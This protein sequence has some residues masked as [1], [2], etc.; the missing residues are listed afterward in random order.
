MEQ[1]HIIHRTVDD[2]ENGL[3]SE[4]EFKSSST[5]K[6]ET[7]ESKAVSVNVKELADRWTS[8]A[9]ISSLL[10]GIAASFMSIDLPP[11]AS[12]WLAHSA[13]VSLCV[14]FVSCLIA[15]CLYMF[16]STDLVH[17]MSRYHKVSFDQRSVNGAHFLAA[18]GFLALMCGEFVMSIRDDM[19]A[20]ITCGAICQLV[21]CGIGL[22]TWCRFNGQ[23]ALAG[24]S[25]VEQK[26]GSRMVY[27][28]L[29]D[30]YTHEKSGD[31]FLLDKD[32]FV[33]KFRNEGAMLKKLAEKVFDSWVE[34]R[35]EGMLDADPGF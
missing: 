20:G 11:T 27:A 33:T 35:L 23:M 34:H 9:V 12:P 15:A 21:L 32:E 17:R 16:F 22:W 25:Q 30:Y 8:L 13:G 2:L 6:D 10:A 29:R 18:I 3:S 26:A 7:T 1:Q 28:R 14:A 5:C 24:A 19:V 4:S 31:F